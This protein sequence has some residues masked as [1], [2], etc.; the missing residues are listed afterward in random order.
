MTDLDTKISD[1]ANEVRPMPD[2]FTVTLVDEGANRVWH[3]TATVEEGP[4]AGK[5]VPLTLG[6]PKAADT[7][8]T[9]RALTRAAWECLELV[10]L[11]NLGEL[12]KIDP[13]VAADGP[14]VQKSPFSPALGGHVDDPALDPDP[15][16]RNIGPFDPTKSTL[17]LERDG[18]SVSGEIDPIDGTGVRDLHDQLAAKLQRERSPATAVAPLSPNRTAELVTSEN[19]ARAAANGHDIVEEPGSHSL[20]CKNC[21]LPEWRCVDGIPCKAAVKAA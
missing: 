21:G 12:A 16:K 3:D 10:R 17:I 11:G 9:V 8:E 20:R 14:A 1:V 2:N 19:R 5:G 7:P 18:V 15:R 6:F 4:D 13:G